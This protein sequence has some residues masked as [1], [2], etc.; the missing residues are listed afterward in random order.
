LAGIR[1]LL[2]F[3]WALQMY[4]FLYIFEVP[5]TQF[6]DE[7]QNMDDNVLKFDLEC[8]VPCRRGGWFQPG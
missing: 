5:W 2:F 4:Q 1:F 8:I 3:V 6:V 7:F